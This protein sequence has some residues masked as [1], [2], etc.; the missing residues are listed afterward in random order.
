[1]GY[2]YGFEPVV[3][4]KEKPRLH[5]SRVGRKWARLEARD[6]GADKASIK[7]G[8]SRDPSRDLRKIGA[9]D[10]HF[11]RYGLSLAGTVAR[12]GEAGQNLP[13]V[14]PLL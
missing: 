2:C 13:R 12:G 5:D 9:G 7:G 4:S 6:P 14:Y 11:G 1:M 3:F 8:V 10:C